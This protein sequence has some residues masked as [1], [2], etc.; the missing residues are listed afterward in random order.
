LRACD[1]ELAER[2]LGLLCVARE[3]VSFHKLT[4]RCGAAPR[5]VRAVLAE[6]QPHLLVAGREV[7]IFHD[8]FRAAL[9]RELSPLALRRC[10][11][12]MGQGGEQGGSGGTGDELGPLG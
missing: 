12:E 3:P 1:A 6:A 2:V 8:S 11:E 9:E 7:M 10:R 4:E 5:Q